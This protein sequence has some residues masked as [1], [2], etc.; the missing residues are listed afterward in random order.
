MLGVI[1]LRT[2]SAVVASVSQEPLT[3]LD[4]QNPLGTWVITSEA[5]SM[6]LA[7]IQ[8]NVS[9]CSHTKRRLC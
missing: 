9:V 4:G 8:V 6:A 3:V 1:P 2:I 5:G 7:S